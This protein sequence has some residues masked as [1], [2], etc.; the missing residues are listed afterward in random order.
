MPYCDT[1]FHVTTGDCTALG[2]A[3]TADGSPT[4]CT[5]MSY[6]LGPDGPIDAMKTRLG[7][8]AKPRM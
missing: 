1:D 6:I 2:A 5:S 8:C 3:A 7:L 4:T